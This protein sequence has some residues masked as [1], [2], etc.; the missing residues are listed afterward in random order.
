MFVYALTY[1]IVARYPLTKNSEDVS[2][3]LF[4]PI[5]VKNI[6]YTDKFTNNCPAAV[7]N[8]DFSNIDPSTNN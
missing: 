2:G 3:K 6:K 7:F 8:R 5:T 4:N 1:N